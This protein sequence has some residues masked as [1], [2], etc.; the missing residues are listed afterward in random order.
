MDTQQPRRFFSLSCKGLLG[1]VA[2]HF[3]SGYPAFGSKDGEDKDSQI[4]RIFL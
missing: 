4:L 3:S 2:I 1:S